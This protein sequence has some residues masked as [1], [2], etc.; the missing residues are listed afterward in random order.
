[1]RAI[2]R[3]LDWN[4]EHLGL[5][6]EQLTSEA[7]PY[8]GASTDG[9]T[10]LNQAAVITAI[11]PDTVAALLPAYS[12]LRT[13]QDLYELLWDMRQGRTRALAQAVVLAQ[14][15]ADA[16]D[17]VGLYRH[18]SELLRGQLLDRI[19]ELQPWLEDARAKT[20]A[21]LASR[22]QV[23]SRFARWRKPPAP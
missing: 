21:E 11:R 9:W 8:P 10:H 14:G 20:K 23:S 7:M 19:E 4:E 1:V 5:F 12:R 6:A 13:I 15:T 2:D 16:E 3:D 22:A 17:A 18:H